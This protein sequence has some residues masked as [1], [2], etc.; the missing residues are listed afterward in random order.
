MRVSSR[1]YK[2]K[3]PGEEEQT[4][5]FTI[6]GDTNPTAFF[7]NSKEMSNFQ[8]ITA[9]MTSFSRQVSNGAPVASI[10]D[11]MKN[12]FDPKGKYI[13][14]DGS[15]REANS[16]VHHL[17]LILEKHMDELK[18]REFLLTMYNAGID[19]GMNHLDASTYAEEQLE[20]FEKL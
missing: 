5:Y 12:T 2:L 6:V 16:I 4:A 19:K 3:V 15:G 7:V 1:T 18:N 14:P 13:I 17:G 8:W 11:D 10:I 9:L 20:L